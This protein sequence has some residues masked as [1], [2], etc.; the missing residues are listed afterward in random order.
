MYGIWKKVVVAYSNVGPDK[1]KKI[2]KELVSRFESYQT[3][4]R[5]QLF[6]TGS[7]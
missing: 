6:D 7:R 5:V 2:T 1:M 4:D 3:R